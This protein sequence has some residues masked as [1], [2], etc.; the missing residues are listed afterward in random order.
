M[1]VVFQK[2][3]RVRA[4]F[5]RTAWNSAAKRIVTC[6]VRMIMVSQGVQAGKLFIAL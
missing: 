4:D 6:V 2:V 5:N 1:L 3:E